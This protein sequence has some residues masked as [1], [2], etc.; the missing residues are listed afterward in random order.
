MIHASLR[1]VA[2]AAGTLLLAA[3]A[4]GAATTDTP[5]AT[6]APGPGGTAAPAPTGGR[7]PAVTF[8]ATQR[9]PYRIE[10]RDSLTLQYEGGASQDQVRE[11]TAFV[12]LTLA[13]APPVGYRVTLALDS[14]QATEN[15]IPVPFDSTAAV[16]GT[17]WTGT[18]TPSGELLDLKAN[19]QS[20]LGDEIASTL[21]HLFPTLPEGGVRE[22]MTWS[23][24]NRYQVV[25]DAFPGTETVAMEYRASEAEAP[26]GR[27]AI[28][29]ESAGTYDRSGTR[30]QG[31]QELQMTASGNR[32]ESHRLAVEGTLLAAQGTDEGEMTITVPAVGQTVPVR[33]TSTYR[34][35]LAAG[36]R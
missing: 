20:T 5:T 21:R 11:R 9:T 34:I 7:G 33:Q 35:N 17:E 28:A 3:C 8:R 16:R 12:H 24:T 29:L 36:G 4:S 1:P 13:D 31:E 14:L 19:R 27:K 2:L 26:G 18:L 30:V 25:A 22:G 23:D 15:G 6:P 10:R 32:K